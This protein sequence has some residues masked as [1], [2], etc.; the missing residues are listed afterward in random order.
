[1]NQCFL[2]K[3]HILILGQVVYKISLY[4]L[5]MAESKEVTSLHQKQKNNYGDIPKGHRNQLKEVP[6]AKAGQ[7]DKL[8]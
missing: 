7:Y 6:M 3:Y 4:D 1:M 8:K 5:V 2:E